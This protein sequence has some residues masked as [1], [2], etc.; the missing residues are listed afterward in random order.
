MKP[1][2]RNVKRSLLIRTT[3]LIRLGGGVLF[4]VL[5]IRPHVD[6]LARQ[7]L[8]LGGNFDNGKHCRSSEKNFSGD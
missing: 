2:E 1:I 4:C 6:R 7:L 3:S 5:I 8:L